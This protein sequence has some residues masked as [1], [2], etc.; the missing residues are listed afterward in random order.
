MRSALMVCSVVLC[1]CGTSLAQVRPDRPD[2]PRERSVRSEAEQARPDSS[3]RSQVQR[4]S[5]ARFGAGADSTAPLDFQVY[6]AQN[7]ALD[8]GNSLN[9]LFRDRKD[10]VVVPDALSNTLLIRAEPQMLQRLTE[11]L[12]QLDRTPKS[13]QFEVVLLDLQIAT[14]PPIAAADDPNAENPQQHSSSSD[15]FKGSV[16]D[17]RA[18]ID[19]RQEQGH[20]KVLNRFE[21]MATDNNPTR[22]QFGVRKPRVTGAQ[23]SGRGNAGNPWSTSVTMENVGTLMGV[24]SRVNSEGH[25]VADIDF[26]KS[27][28]GSEEDGKVI[29]EVDGRDKV[30]VPSMTTLSI[31]Q[32]IQ[33]ISGSAQ[34]IA[35]AA[36]KS[37][38]SEPGRYLLVVGATIAEGK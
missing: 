35:A 31:K 8:L 38:V 7:P 2:S 20:V 21:L 27:F 28:L 12:D 5:V 30:V 18:M 29:A 23:F 10:V 34:P 14:N 11:A 6:R 33:L 24:T 26:E 17:V 16:D 4:G 15:E 22:I 19:Q 1:F 37:D 9:L 32:T 3:P 25:I 13:V 36:G